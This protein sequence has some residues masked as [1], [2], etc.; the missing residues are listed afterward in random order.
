MLFIANEDPIIQAGVK[1]VTKQ[2]NYPIL[3]NKISKEVIIGFDPQKYEKLAT[4]YFAVASA[5]AG[6]VFGGE[7]QPV[8]QTPVQTETPQPA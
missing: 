1:Q 2:D 7:Q 3:L 5:S 4:D 6:S 8:A